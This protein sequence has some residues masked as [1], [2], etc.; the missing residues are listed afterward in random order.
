LNDGEIVAEDEGQ[1]EWECVGLLEGHE[2]EC[3]SVAYSSSGTL[4]ASCSRDKTVW[5]WEVQSDNDF[6]C[7]GVLMEHNQDVK[8]V[9]WHPKQEILAS[10]SYDDTIK[11]YVDDPSED[12]FCFA[13]LTGHTSTVWSLAWEPKG[14]YLASASEDHTVRIW[15]QLSDHRWLCVLVLEN[16]ERAVYSVSWT[17]G[18]GTEEGSLGWLASTGSDGTINVWEFSEANTKLEHKH[19]ARHFSAHGVSDVNSVVWCPHNG[20]RDLLASAGDDGLV[21]VWRISTL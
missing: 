17:T 20:F 12:W 5:V 19:I 4:L 15:K 1:A 14:R 8:S 18:E 10:A 3:K 13:T 7:L 21:R 16:H 2:T 11:L 9:A 6:E